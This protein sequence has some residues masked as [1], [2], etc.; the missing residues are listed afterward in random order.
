MVEHA[1]QTVPA[2]AIFVPTLSG[3]TVRMISRFKPAPWIIAASQDS[4]ISRGLLFSYGVHTVEIAAD[5][6]NWADY[7]TDWLT[8]EFGPGGKAVLLTFSRDLRRITDGVS[9]FYLPEE[10]ESFL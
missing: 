3:A 1:I 6:G 5:P 8:K 2:K 10:A 9:Q 7:A 4:A